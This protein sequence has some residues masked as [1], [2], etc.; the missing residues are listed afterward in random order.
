[1]LLDFPLERKR[2]LNLFNNRFNTS[3]LSNTN[4]THIRAFN[5]II[6]KDIN[7]TSLNPLFDNVYF[8]NE[9]GLRKPN[10]DAFKFVLEQNNYV[11]SETL[12]LDDSPQHLEGA[13]QIGIHTFHIQDVPIEKIFSD[14]LLK[15]NSN[16]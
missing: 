8:S 12:F 1:M 6:Q 5:Q 13:K 4:E 16:S 11:P 14:L 15:S 10:T 7:E 3:L 9:I 2:L